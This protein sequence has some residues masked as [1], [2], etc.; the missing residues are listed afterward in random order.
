MNLFL[1]VFRPSESRDN[2]W[3]I[4]TDHYLHNRDD[5]VLATFFARRYTR[6]WNP[7]VIRVLPLPF[8]L[9]RFTITN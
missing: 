1:G 9:G 2:L 6:W 4:T 7:D 3:D 5:D 8:Q